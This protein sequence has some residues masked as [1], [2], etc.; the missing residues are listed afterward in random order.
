[1]ILALRQQIELISLD[2]RTEERRTADVFTIE[3]SMDHFSP[4]PPIVSRST[5]ED[6]D[7]G[8]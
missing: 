4:P 2:R 6:F 8:R 3:L 7:L 1:M 5:S